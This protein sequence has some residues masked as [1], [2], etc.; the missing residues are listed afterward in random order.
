MSVSGHADH[1]DSAVHYALE[2][3][4]AVAVCPFRPDLVIRIG[5]EPAAPNSTMAVG[6]LYS[7]RALAVSCSGY[8]PRPSACW[9]LPCGAATATRKRR[10]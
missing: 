2:T 10:H 8:K 3:T 7:A 4:H 1:L 9:R 6:S 5:D